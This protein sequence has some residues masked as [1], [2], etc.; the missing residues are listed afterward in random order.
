[1]N[2]LEFANGW[3]IPGLAFLADWSVRW[4]I[5]LALFLSWLAVRP[6]RDAASRY[7]ICATLLAAGMIL[8]FVPRWALAPLPAPAPTI[9]I[10]T[11]NM[12]PVVTPYRS[13]SPPIVGSTVARQPERVAP[14]RSSPNQR[15]GS[16]D[17]F[18]SLGIGHLM[19]IIVGC[20]WVLIALVLIFRLLAGRLVLAKLRQEAVDIGG[21]TD[22]LLNDC[23]RA[24]S[25]SRPVV[26]AVH[27]SVGSPV[28]LG[29]RA[30]LVLVPPDW[31]AWTDSDRRACLLHELAH[32]ARRDDFAKTAQEIIRCPFFF[33]PL[34]HWL[35]R[36]LDRERELIC[37]EAA[38]ALGADPLAYARLLLDLARRPGASCRLQTIFVGHRSCSSTG[39]RSWCASND[40]WR[41]T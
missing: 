29:G 31:D 3:V 23:R 35:L 8:P 30:P 15:A 2:L 33:H 28:T 22:S 17:S 24:L 19:A 16:P 20:A 40:S 9:P 21:T 26:V 25:L 6:P 27:P 5:L 14:P 37:D 18:A 34:V 39:G 4:G 7:L 36:R 11:P 41:T 32:L 12:F 13:A 10:A 38:V 1:M